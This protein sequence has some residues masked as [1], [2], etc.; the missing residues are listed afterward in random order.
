MHQHI[1]NWI[2]NHYFGDKCG[3]QCSMVTWNEKDQPLLRAWQRRMNLFLNELWWENMLLLPKYL[4][5]MRAAVFLA[6]VGR[7]NAIS[8]AF[9]D[10]LQTSC[11]WLRKRLN[12]W[13][14]KLPSTKKIWIW[15]YFT[16]FLSEVK[17]TKCG[18]FN[19][20]TGGFAIK[21]A[22]K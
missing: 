5:V 14:L 7:L 13:I 12:V 1:R 22:A 18:I 16:K 9:L 10:V 20:V 3:T 21:C 19:G 17:S 11:P 4:S 2:S 8:E 6:F 15:P